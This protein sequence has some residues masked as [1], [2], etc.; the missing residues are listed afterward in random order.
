MK[1]KTPKKLLKTSIIP[2][3][4]LLVAIIGY[5][6][7]AYTNN[8]F[9]FIVEKNQSTNTNKA[10]ENG[11]NYNSPTS[12]QKQAGEAQK[13]TTA[14]ST[15]NTVDNNNQKS[16]SVTITALSQN[17]GVVQIRGLIDVVS[18]VGT[19]T[20]T[21]AKGSDVVTKEAGVQAL[22]SESTCKG[23]DVPTSELSVGLWTA[24]LGVHIGSDEGSASKSFAV[25]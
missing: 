2:L 15:S 4:I 5:G 3:T 9:P 6:A 24:T 13:K 10:T 8:F 17:G 11:V 16:L 14:P 21:L 22:P 12:E 25:K 7:L 19:C 20:L 18:S 1:I 23:F